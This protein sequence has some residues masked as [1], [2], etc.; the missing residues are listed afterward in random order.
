MNVADAVLE[1]LN[2]AAQSPSGYVHRTA[3]RSLL[4]ASTDLALY[5]LATARR[6]T[7]ALSK[8]ATRSYLHDNGFT[9]IVF[10]GL[11]MQAPELR[12][13]VWGYPDLPAPMRRGLKPSN[14]HDHSADFCSVLLIGHMEERIFSP[15]PGGAPAQ[16]AGV[17]SEFTCGSRGE[18]RSYD[19]AYRDQA[20]LYILDTATMAPG[21]IHGMRADIL[22]RITVTDLPTITLFLQGP[23]R[24]FGTSV[25]SEQGADFGEQIASPELE[26]GE[27]LKLMEWT[28]HELAKSKE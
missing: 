9:K 28:D 20:E 26:E 11:G 7:E 1:Y 12:L 16:P 17:F 25:Y 13:H 21:S 18:H 27:L 24:R 5:L 15:Y 19:L 10:G 2:E 22:H 8:V 4:M 23:R 14:I 6:S 3:T